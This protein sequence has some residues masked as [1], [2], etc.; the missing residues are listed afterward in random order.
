MYMDKHTFLNPN[1]S[2][3]YKATVSILNMSA[4]WRLDV[5]E[6]KHYNTAQ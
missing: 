3:I 6:R 1:A 5:P 4:R 2:T